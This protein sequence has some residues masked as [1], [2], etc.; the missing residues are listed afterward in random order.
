M[1]NSL[2]LII[3]IIGLLYSI[4]Y[5]RQL[6]P[7]KRKQF[8]IKYGLYFAAAILLLLVMTGRLH[9]VAAGLAALLP[10]AQK[11]F[12]TGM[13]LMPFLKYWQ[14]KKQGK[15]N[16]E[17]ASPAS[18]FSGK[19][20]VKEAQEIMGLKSLESVAQVSKRHKELMQK[21]HPDRG[22]SDYLAAQINQAKETL[23][24][25]LKT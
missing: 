4:K 18:S 24:N 21:M 1:I 22:G 23:T 6:P 20:S 9:W 2:L 25:H 10:L 11:L 3:A 15:P 5:I 14:A 17:Q 8:I 13:R 16:S 12:Y 7:A 19:M